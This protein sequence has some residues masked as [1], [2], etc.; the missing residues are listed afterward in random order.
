MKT[1]NALLA[2]LLVAA[3]AVRT[4]YCWLYPQW[5]PDGTFADTDHYATLASSL[6]DH[7]AFLDEN[8]APSAEREPVYPLFLATLFKVCGKSYRWIQA[9][10]CALSIATVYL[11]FLLGWLLFSRRAG[12]IALILASF[13]PHFIYY[14]SPV[15][16]ETF[17]T[18]M[19]TA[20]LYILIWAHRRGSFSS[21]LTA[22]SFCSLL[23]LTNTSFLP[24][25]LLAA[26][27]ALYWIHRPRQPRFL[28]LGAA[29]LAPLILIY[30]LWPL[31]NYLVFRTWILGSTAGG[32]GIFY[33]YQVVPERVAGTPLQAEIMRKDPVIQGAG[34]LNPREREKY[35]WK[36]GLKRA[37]ENPKRYLS[38]VVHRF[39]TQW[40]LFP[41]PRDYPHDYSLLW[42]ISLLSD[43]W[44][45][46]LGFL[47]FLL[48]RM[49][50]AETVFSYLLVLTTTGLYA[51][52]STT[53]R[54]RVPMMPYIIIFAALVLDKALHRWIKSWRLSPDKVPA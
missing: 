51:L 28:P 46:P 22:G 40:R 9:A 23:A 29:Y 14:T 4:A 27:L 2:A 7:G 47:G 21:F 35:Y 18:F 53:L 15:L 54:Y 1:E 13:Y 8:G 32:G 43:G 20:A 39:M 45:V 19:S 48:A 42:W 50:P 49:K 10:H 11:I 38:L 24:F 17:L 25:C 3:L 34:G 6:L 5:G 12:W 41:Y 16:R 30:S 37:A 26:P 33:I 52:I 36:A 31:R 44:L